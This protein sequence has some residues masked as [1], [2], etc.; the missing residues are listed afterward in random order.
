MN[1]KIKFLQF[2][3]QIAN[4]NSNDYNINNNDYIIN[5]TSF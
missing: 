1:A 4:L 2:F 5:N 3:L